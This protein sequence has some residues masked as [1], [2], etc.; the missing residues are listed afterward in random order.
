MNNIHRLALA[1]LLGVLLS[2]CDNSATLDPQ[3]QVGPNPELPEA[4]NFLLPPMQ[5]PEGVAWKEGE[6]PK[7]AQGLKIEKIA[8]GLM[9]PRQVYV[10]PNNDILVAE[11]NGTP[12]PTTRPKQLIMGVVQKASGKGG[13]GGNRITLLRNVNGKW[14]KHHFIENLNAPFGIQL[15][16]NTLW[17]ANA[18][19]LVKFPYQEGQTEIRTP[20]EEVTE[21]PGGPINHH[22]TKALLASP[23]G[24]KLYVG[25]GSNS[26][27]TENGIGAEYRRAAVLEV[28]AATGASRIYASG[29]RNPTGLQWEPESG[30]LWA[31]V[32]ERDEIG[33][34][35]VPDYMTSVQEKG[36][37]GWPYSYFG[38]HVDKR[39][40]PQRPDLVA[41]AIKPDYAL[42]SHVAPLGLHFYTG[43]NM[44]QYRGG[45]FVSEHGSWN[46][47]P[48]NG[49][50]V[51]WV[52]FENGKP[53][54]MP[55]PVVTGF[56]TDD[57]KQVRGLPVGVTQDKSG[58]LLIADDAGNA[59]WRVS[60]AQ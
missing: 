56:L 19:S 29:L 55:Q 42:G 11:S 35:L 27:I 18:D 33:S 37:Y 31:I 26:N 50:Q 16:G 23:D 52:K 20:G 24:S 45:A 36:F 40:E 9:H 57:Q 58:A 25:V 32:N 41:K 46:R 43:D 4:K 17:V 1:V 44:P 15:T 30:K 48:L 39:A 51:V 6:K 28:D 53:V 47:S 22:W 49:Y 3:K 13:P 7:V 21:L 38:N 54:G 12:K 34:D 8:D 60:A 5:V 10:L 14:E 2:G 59:I